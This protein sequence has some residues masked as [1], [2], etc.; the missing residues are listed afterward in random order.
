MFANDK[1]NAVLT[2]GLEAHLFCYYANMIVGLKRV[3]N[4]RKISN[5]AWDLRYRSVTDYMY[6][7]R[8]LWLLQAVDNDPLRNR[9]ANNGTWPRP[10]WRSLHTSRLSTERS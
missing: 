4:L 8:V 2:S 10:S 5:T 1:R 9:N 3:S 7:A 6:L